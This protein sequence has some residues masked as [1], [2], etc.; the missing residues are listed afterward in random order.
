[1]DSVRLARSDSGMASPS[2]STMPLVA[3]ATVFQALR[4]SSCMN[5]REWAGGKNVARNC[6]EARRLVAS[7]K[8]PGLNSVR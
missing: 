2:A 3:M 1:M 4:T 6:F 8:T 7:K 5:A